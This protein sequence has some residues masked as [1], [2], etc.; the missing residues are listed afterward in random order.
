ME[1]RIAG[2]PVG[3]SSGGDTSLAEHGGARKGRPPGKQGPRKVAKL[4]SGR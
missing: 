3:D 2:R 1:E 4:V